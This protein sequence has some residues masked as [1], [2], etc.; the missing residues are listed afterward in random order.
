MA[1]IQQLLNSLKKGDEKS[2]TLIKN[3]ILS[4]GVKGLAVLVSL[5][6]LPIFMDY[7]ED[8]AILGIWFS[9]LSMLNWVLTFDLGIGNGLRN[10]LVI[11]LEK[12]DND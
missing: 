7:F 3:I 4:F 1:K 9:L 12:E 11:A 5:I 2:K 6:N 10:Y 8:S